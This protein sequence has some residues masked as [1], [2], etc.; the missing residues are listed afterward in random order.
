[1]SVNIRRRQVRCSLLGLVLVLLLPGISQADEVYLA[2]G[3]RLVGEIQRLAA[4]GLVIETAFAGTLD[5][6]RDQVLGVVS[7]APLTVAIEGGERL[8]GRLDYDPEDGQQLA[9]ERLGEISLEQPEITAL[10]PA[11]EAAPVDE[12]VERAVAAVAAEKDA[13]IEALEARQAQYA[14]PWSGSVALGISGSE[15]NTEETNI[16]AAIN[17]KREVEDDR[18]ILSFLADYAEQD[19]ETT[20]NEFIGMGRL[21]HDLSERQFIF[22]QASL[23]TDEFEDIDLR[24]IVLGGYGYFFLQQPKHTLKGR[25]GVGVQKESFDSGGSSTD[26]LLQLGY[27]HEYL[28]SDWIKFTDSLT[29]LPVLDDLG[30]YRLVFDAAVELP[31]GEK[32]PW[33]LRA[34]INAQYDSDPE[35]GV[36]DVDINYLL[37]LVY[38]VK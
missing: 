14:D 21:E 5:I 26:A 1:M 20:S 33:A 7:E 13:E 27:D 12:D 2:D 31:L 24:A 29:Y 16:N 3:S 4:D 8:V 30:D 23:E 15:G 11:D 10:W 18:L 19:S 36:D 35:P 6:P 17:F 25:V 32:K 38:N 34:G 37:N 9:S 28:Y 22:G